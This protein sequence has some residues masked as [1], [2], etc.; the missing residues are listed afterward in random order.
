MS[1]APVGPAMNED[2][3]ALA[4][5]FVKCLLRLIRAQ[6]SYGSWE[7]RADT[8]LL[9]DF[10]ITK[11]QRRAIPII[12]DPAPDVLWRLDMFYTAVRLAIE[13]GS[14][15]ITSPMMEMKPMGASSAWFSRSGGWV[16]LSRRPPVRLRD[17][18][19]T[20]GGR[21]ET[22]RRCDCSYCLSRG[23]GVKK[24]ISRKDLCQT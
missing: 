8:E 5:P 18:P 22:G 15:L 17:F 2:K 20:R 10:I 9:A 21:Y 19:E 23:A 12:A 3:A 6:D 14:G 4:N 16:V 13:E 24:P 11:E 1:D 7:G